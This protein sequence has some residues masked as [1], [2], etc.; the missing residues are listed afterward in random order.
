MLEAYLFANH[1][2]R[3]W[4]NARQTQNKEVGV[5]MLTTRACLLVLFVPFGRQCESIDSTRFGL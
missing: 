4:L 1:Q 3:D 5:C 2:Q